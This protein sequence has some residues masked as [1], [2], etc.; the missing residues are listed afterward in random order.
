LEYVGVVVTHASNDSSLGE[1]Q[2]SE[3]ADFNETYSS[4]RWRSFELLPTHGS[5]ITQNVPASHT[6]FLNA[7]KICDSQIEES[8]ANCSDMSERIRGTFLPATYNIRFLPNQN[9]IFWP[10]LE[11]IGKTNLIYTSVTANKSV[12]RRV[13]NAAEAGEIELTGGKASLFVLRADWIDCSGDTIL[14]KPRVEDGCGVC[15]GDGSS[16]SD[17]NGVLHGSKRIL[18][19]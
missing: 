11:G 13:S 7:S 2:W 5:S 1:W 4:T 3:A 9:Q 14:T 16:C 17:C 18:M 12:I 10:L 6:G 8:I 19:I 15:G